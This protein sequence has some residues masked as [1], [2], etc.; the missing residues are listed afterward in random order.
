MAIDIIDGALIEQLSEKQNMTPDKL[1]T[2]LYKF[3]ENN[4]HNYFPQLPPKENRHKDTL[5]KTPIGMVSGYEYNGLTK[6]EFKEYINSDINKRYPSI[7]RQLMTD[8]IDYTNF[9]NKEQYSQAIRLIHNIATSSMHSRSISE[10]MCFGNDTTYKIEHSVLCFSLY[11]H[12][13]RYKKRRK[14][15]KYKGMLPAEIINVFGREYIK[16]TDNR[17]MALDIINYFKNTL[18]IKKANSTLSGD[19]KRMPKTTSKKA[20][21]YLITS[22]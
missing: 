16:I 6:S 7:K 19:Y 3:I 18:E 2:L 22:Y 8:I 5:K 13:S 4:Q 10:I 14:K 15:T 21:A 20:Y 11:T 9:D 17:D 12:L 1:E